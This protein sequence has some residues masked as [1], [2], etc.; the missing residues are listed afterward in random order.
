V[1]K[2]V[3]LRDLFGMEKG[4]RSWLYRLYYVVFDGS[5]YRFTLRE[6]REFLASAGAHVVAEGHSR[7]DVIRNRHCFFLIRKAESNAS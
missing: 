7:P 3:L 2:I 4:L 6:W 1:G 5:E